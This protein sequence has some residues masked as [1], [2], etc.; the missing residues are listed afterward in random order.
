MLKN[1]KKDCG[2]MEKKQLFPKRDLWGG[3]CFSG[4]AVLC[5]GC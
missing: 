3:L 1:N 5:V 4:C 2:G